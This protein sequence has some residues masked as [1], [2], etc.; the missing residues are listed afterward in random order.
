MV[1]KRNGFIKYL[2]LIL[3]VTNQALASNNER[4]ATKRDREEISSFPQDVLLK[5]EKITALPK[6]R[7]KKVLSEAKKIQYAQ[8]RNEHKRQK[9]LEA[10]NKE[11]QE[12]ISRHEQ[13]LK[14]FELHPSKL[15]KH[16]QFVKRAFKKWKESGKS[17]T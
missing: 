8:V 6:P 15:E 17:T 2:I 12:W 9:A 5:E 1:F 14:D 16:S 3:M 10:K 7:S 4:K 13:D 11:L